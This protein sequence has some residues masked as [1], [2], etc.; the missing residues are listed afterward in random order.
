MVWIIQNADKTHLAAICRIEKEVF[1]GP[2]SPT[3]LEE[4]LGK[5]QSHVRVGF[6]R[7][8]LGLKPDILGGFCINW[9]IA[10]ELNL[11]QIAVDSKYQQKGLGGTLLRDS[12]KLAKT[13]GTIGIYLEVRASNTPAIHLYRSYGFEQVG[14][15]K[16]YYSTPAEDAFVFSYKNPHPQMIMRS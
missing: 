2:W 10:D 14:T 11:L 5:K 9:L 15:R 4:E 6:Y 3:M 1:L 7:D 16:N 12:I 8:P 13:Y